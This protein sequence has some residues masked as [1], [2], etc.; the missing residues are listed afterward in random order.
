MRGDVGHGG[1]GGGLVIDRT[2]QLHDAMTFTIA[3]RADAGGRVVAM[4]DGDDARADGEPEMHDAGVG[5]DERPGARQERGRLGEG[6]LADQVVVGLGFADEKGVEFAEAFPLVLA[7]E[8]KNL[9]VQFTAA[10]LEQLR[11]TL[12]RPVAP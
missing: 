7:A 9:G 2:R 10:M 4:D 5:G 1:V 11:V 6:K 3:I 12:A 8:D